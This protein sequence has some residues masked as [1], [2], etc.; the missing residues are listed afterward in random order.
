MSGWRQPRFETAL[1]HETPSESKS[2]RVCYRRATQ[3]LVFWHSPH[4]F[5]P[6]ERIACARILQQNQASMTRATRCEA[7]TAETID[8]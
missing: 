6:L 7:R 4:G 5:K 1:Q 8:G 3:R 2:V